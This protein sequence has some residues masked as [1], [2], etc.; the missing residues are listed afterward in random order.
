MG[1]N[2]HNISVNRT[3]GGIVTIVAKYGV[4]SNGWQE[5]VD[6]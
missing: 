3:H 2:V 4:V 5:V 1:V 6:T